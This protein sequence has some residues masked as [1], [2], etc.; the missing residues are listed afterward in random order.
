[1]AC[2]DELPD[3]AIYAILSHLEFRRDLAVCCLVSKNLRALATSRLYHTIYLG[4]AVHVEQIARR[5]VEEGLAVAQ[6]RNPTKSR[7]AKKCTSSYVRCLIFDDNRY[8]TLY[9]RDELLCDYSISE[10]QP[11]IPYL[12]NLTTLAWRSQWLPE[13]TA[14]FNSLRTHCSQL[15]S[16]EIHNWFHVF[17]PTPDYY[18]DSL[19]AFTNLDRLAINSRFLAHGQNRLPESIIAAIRASPNLKSLELDLGEPNIETDRTWSPN[20]LF[21]EVGLTFPELHTLRLGGRV[22]LQWPLTL[23]KPSTFFRLFFERHQMLQSISIAWAPGL[24]E[25]N[26]LGPETVVSLFPSV[27]HFEG[28]AFLCASM[29]RSPLALQLESLSRSRQAAWK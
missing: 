11:A 17:E 12:K 21:K 5:F 2:F 14:L 7:L 20:K 8:T 15:R 4:F 28:P 19:F 6:A 27:H 25:Q 23:S 29:L 1:M 16:V 22:V 18:A 24:N 9:K 3:V 13:K 26:D 10:L